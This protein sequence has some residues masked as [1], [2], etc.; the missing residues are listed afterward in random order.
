MASGAVVGQILDIMYPAAN[1]AALTMRQGGS[2]PAERVSVHAFDAATIEYLDFKVMIRG[3]GGG[4]FTVDLPWSAASATSG[5]TRWEGAFRRVADDAEDIDTSQTYDY[6]TVDA[7][8]A[9]VSGEVAYDVL[10]FT[11]GA[12]ADTVANGDICIFRVR[13][14]ASHANDTM[15]GDAELWG[16]LIRET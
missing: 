3:Y 15:S 5:V 7:T 2:T 4:G 11:D 16:I 14:N 13:R 9:N 10:T 12:D 1:F 6:N 8:A